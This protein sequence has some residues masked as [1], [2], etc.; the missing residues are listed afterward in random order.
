LSGKPASIGLLVGMI[1]AQIVAGIV[2]GLFFGA[3][4]GLIYKGRKNTRLVIWTKAFYC[5]ILSFLFV[6][7]C[8]QKF[9]V[10]G[11]K[12]SFSNAKYIACFCMGYS[13]NRFWGDEGVP[14]KET[15]AI[16]QLMMPWLFGS[17]GASLLVR[18]VTPQSVAFSIAHIFVG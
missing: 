16:F 6:F 2:G 18:V 4:G 17:I 1:V 5:V 9:I 14:L 11:E 3:L 13:L 15:K 8:A 7:A 10:Q 12:Y